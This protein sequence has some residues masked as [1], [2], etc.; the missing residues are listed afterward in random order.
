[1][2]IQ[3]NRETGVFRLETKRTSYQFQA[4]ELGVLLHLYYG[5]TVEGE[6]THLIQKHD[7]GYAGNPYEAGRDRTYSLDT[8]PQEFPSNGVGDYRIGCVG[9][10]G[11][12]GSRAADFRY[13]SHRVTAGAKKITGMPALYDAAASE[14]RSESETLEVTL[15]DEA[16]H[17]EAVL[18]Y[19]VFAEKDV[20][21]RSVKLRNCGEEALVLEKMLS[22]CLDLP[23][24][25]WELVH[26]HGRHAMERMMERSPLVHG[27]IRLGSIR[28]TS[29]H[30]QNPTMILCSPDATEEHGDCYGMALVYSSNFT[31][32]VELDQMNQVRAVM[33]INPESFNYV[34]DGGMEFET[35]QVILSYTKDGFG[36]LSHIFHRIMRHNLCRGK[37]Q[38]ARRPVLINNWE[39]TY[40]DC[41]KEKILPIARQAAALGVEMLVLDDGWFGKR[42]DDYSGLGD[43]YVNEDKMG[44]TLSNLVKEINGMGLKFGIWVEPEMV[45]EDSG[46][47]RAHPDWALTIPGRKP[48]RGRYQLVLD[49]SRADV[50][51]YIF[52]MLK[53]VLNSANIEYVKWD[54]NRSMCD[55]YSALA[56][57]EHQGEIYHRCMLGVYDL[58]ERFVTE[59]PDILLEGCSGGGGRF[60]P[61]ML[62]YSPQIW[63]SDD[64]D[65]IERLEIQ[66]GTSFFYPV[67]AVGSH[68]SASPNHQTGRSTPVE[69]RA[70]VAMAGS[71]GYELD[72]NLLTEEEKEAVKRQIADF[73]RYYD[74]I[75]NGTYYRLLSP[76]GKQHVTAWQSVSEDR[77][78]SLVSV[79]CTH[80]RANLADVCIRLR[81]LDEK[82]SYRIEG[83]DRVYTGSALMY[84]GLTIPGLH[85][86]CPSRRLYVTEM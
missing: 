79:V 29:S 20:I 66:Y 61:A 45:S 50:R 10:V 71:F 56:G 42:D 81:G 11:A 57:K 3:Y 16:L 80:V 46:L 1:M 82:K 41:R 52:V 59:F 6:M 86:D 54:M 36:D 76:Y 22:V 49:L 24:G 12:D 35:P 48:C 44:G 8:L 67:S 63:C 23:Y 51:D 37:Y 64:T 21:A 47:Y 40:F 65:A 32:E 7:I 17:A 15:R 13:V 68:V 69:T 33:G 34:L 62:Y 4:D 77:S 55:I 58:L 53:Q 83:D 14:G 38:F 72:L 2:A 60:D 74:V 84:G 27:S 9:I 39:A 85:G 28:G 18:I 73:K 26:F 25:D 43:W 75:Q 30:H 19:T 70:V 5:R 78:E 31:A